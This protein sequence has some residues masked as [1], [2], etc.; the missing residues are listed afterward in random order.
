MTKESD[1]ARLRWERKFS[2]ESGCCV[3]VQKERL[4]KALDNFGEQEINQTPKTDE[5]QKRGMKMK[6]VLTVVA[7]ALA[8]MSG[9]VNATPFNPMGGRLVT[10]TE[11]GSVVDVVREDV[12]SMGEGG[13]GEGGAGEGGAGEGGA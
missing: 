10:D 13:A 8:A 9:A 3:S 5:T 11:T 2:N 6:N 12:K 1:L 4:Q 7:V